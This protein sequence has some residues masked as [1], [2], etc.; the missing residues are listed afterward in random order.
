VTVFVDTNVILYAAIPDSPPAPACVRILEA[1]LE[2]RLNGVTSTSVLEEV[3]HVELRTSALDLRGVAGLA[4]G[5]FTPLLP[6]TDEVMKLA[7]ELGEPGLGSNDRVHVASCRLNDI[8][9]IVSAD[10]G[11]DSV[12]GLRRVDPLDDAA[13]TAL[14]G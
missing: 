12:A 7:L 4:Y 3:L 5:M 9:V 8:D 10:R 11:F 2:G 6:V 1:A 14:I 13:V